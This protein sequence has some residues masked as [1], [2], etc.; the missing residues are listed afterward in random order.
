[1]RDFAEPEISGAICLLWCYDCGILCRVLR[2]YFKFGDPVVRS[3]SMRISRVFVTNRRGTRGVL[4]RFP[5]I[6]KLALGAHILCNLPWCRQAA[7]IGR[8]APP[9]RRQPVRRSNRF[10]TAPGGLRGETSRMWFWRP[11]LSASRPRDAPASANVRQSRDLRPPPA[12][13]RRQRH[14]PADPAPN[15]IGATR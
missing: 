8:P 7:L 3:E 13:R 10:N 6:K 14:E 11:G 1:M 4:L 12:M 15:R 2:S 5:A 9:A